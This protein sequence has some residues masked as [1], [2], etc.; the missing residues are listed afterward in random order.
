MSR[1]PPPNLRL[2]VREQISLVQSSGA[3][4][5]RW[6][7]QARAAGDS[8]MP[9]YTHLQRAEPVLVRIGCWPMWK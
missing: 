9:S 2:Y 3:W 6:V 1:L 4:A 8:V 5:M 7:E